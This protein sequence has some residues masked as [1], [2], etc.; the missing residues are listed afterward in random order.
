MYFRLLAIY[1]EIGIID[2]SVKLK[3]L[4]HK[5]YKFNLKNIINQYDT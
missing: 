2:N 1:K 5:N 4:F 3:K